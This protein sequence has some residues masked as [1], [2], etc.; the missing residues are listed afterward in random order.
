MEGC[1]FTDA[2][3]MTIDKVV[4]QTG[5]DRWRVEIAALRMRSHPE[6]RGFD[7]L[8]WIRESLSDTMDEIRQA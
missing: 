4:Q 2:E 3:R 1:F 6:L 5:A 8:Q 7:L